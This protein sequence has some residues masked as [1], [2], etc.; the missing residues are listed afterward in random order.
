[1]IAIRSRLFIYQNI[2]TAPANEQQ[3]DGDTEIA[4]DDRLAFSSAI[5]VQ[6]GAGTLVD[7]YLCQAA[8]DQDRPK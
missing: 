1:M 4:H 6:S 8:K 3:G 2:Q 7:A 5:G